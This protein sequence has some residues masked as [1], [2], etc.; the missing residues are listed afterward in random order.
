MKNGNKN[1]IKMLLKIVL[2]LQFWSVMSVTFIKRSYLLLFH[3]VKPYKEKSNPSY[4]KIQ[5]FIINLKVK[6]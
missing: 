5:M 4:F 1:F 3:I 2:D 6:K